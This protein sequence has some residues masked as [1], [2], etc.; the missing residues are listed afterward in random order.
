MVSG[1]L[2]VGNDAQGRGGEKFTGYTYAVR[3]PG[4]HHGPFKSETGCLLLE[5]HDTLLFDA[6]AYDLSDPARGDEGLR[7]A[8][9]FQFAL[10]NGKDLAGWDITNCKVGVEDGALVLDEGNG[11]VRSNLKYGDFV[12]ELDWR[13]RQASKYDSGIYIRSEF[14]SIEA[15]EQGEDKESDVVAVRSNHVSI[16]PIHTSFHSQNPTFACIVVTSGS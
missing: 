8:G 9:G 14:P 5:T 12:L 1:D 13:A 2:I 7:R 10:F 16:T 3:P 11:F 6:M 15:M 4:V